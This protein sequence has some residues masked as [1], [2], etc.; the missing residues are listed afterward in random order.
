MMRAA[1]R[2]ANTVDGRRGTGGFT[3]IELLIVIFIFMILAG[4]VAPVFGRGIRQA[5][6]NTAAAQVA[7][8]LR[9]ARS[10]AIN[11][12]SMYGVRFAQPTAED[13][14]KAVIH[15]VPETEIGSADLWADN[16]TGG[17]ALLDHQVEVTSPTPLPSGIFFMPDGSAWGLGMVTP[18]VITV[19]LKE[20]Y[21]QAGID[22]SRQIMVGSLSGSI[23]VVH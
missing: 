6:M 21:A 2:E 3:I 17:G 20:E 14:W 23:S 10:L 22:D 9:R 7:T 8:A 12:G 18:P 5:R 15:V 19:A 4:L 11:N 1:T 16:D 13:P